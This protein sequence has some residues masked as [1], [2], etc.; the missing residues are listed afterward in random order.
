VTC[1]KLH[2]L[3][4]MESERSFCACLYLLSVTLLKREDLES[5]NRTTAVSNTILLSPF[6]P[7]LPIGAE[8]PSS[9]VNRG[10]IV[11]WN[12]GRVDSLNTERPYFRMLANM[13]SDTGR[14]EERSVKE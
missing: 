6:L 13:K 12:P 9:S 8:V 1:A 11:I 7:P 4:K 10:L 2:T 14:K 5:I 3:W